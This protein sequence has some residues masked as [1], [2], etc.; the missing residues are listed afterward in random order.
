[1][2]TPPCEELD[3]IKIEIARIETSMQDSNYPS[4]TSKKWK[5]LAILIPVVVTIL[6][7]IGAWI[8]AAINSSITTKIQ[9][10]SKET[11]RQ[12]C[13]DLI[14]SQ[15]ASYMMGIQTGREQAKQEEAQKRIENPPPL[16][17]TVTQKNQVKSPH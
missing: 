14:V 10:V 1:M 17:L 15:S 4:K 12:T 6:G 5:R 3:E 7:S 11:A 2:H 8:T 9:S 13:Q 16:G